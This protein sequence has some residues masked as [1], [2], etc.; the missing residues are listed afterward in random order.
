MTPTPDEIDIVERLRAAA[1][2]L[3]KHPCEVYGLQQLTEEAATLISQ[4]RNR[5]NAG[6]KANR[7]RNA[8][9][10]IRGNASTR[11]WNVTKCGE[12]AAQALE[13]DE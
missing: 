10:A 2:I 7:M 8:L 6:E 1:R 13:G 3:V 9:I 4:L 12:I 5:E 11:L